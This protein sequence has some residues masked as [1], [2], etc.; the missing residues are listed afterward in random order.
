MVF[1]RLKVYG[2]ALAII[3]IW[4]TLA[5]G[6]KPP[7]L[8][9][10][11]LSLSHSSPQN[12]TEA[13]SSASSIDIQRDSLKQALAGDFALMMRLITDWDVDA[14]L[15]QAKGF[16]DIER[17]PSSDFLR[18]QMLGRAL[19]SP[20]KNELVRL[21]KESNIHDVIDDTN[22]KISL[23]IKYRRFLP[24]TYAA[25]SFLLALVSPSQIVAL[26]SRLREQIELYPKSV[27]DQIFLDIDR[28]N[29]EKLFE[30]DPEIAFVARYSHPSTLQA[31]RNQG[32]QLYMMEDLN[33]LQ[34]ITNELMNIGRLVARPIEAEL[35][36]LFLFSASMALD[37]KLLLLKNQYIKIN[38]PLPTL[39]YVNHHHNF[40]IPTFKTLTG[41]FL[42]KM[43]SW[44]I[45]LKHAEEHGLHEMWTIPI[46]RE[47]IVNLNPDCLI[48]ATEH[49]QAIE[50]QILQD[51]A[52]QQISAV[53]NRNIYFI[54]ESIQQSSCQYILL[55]YYDL[56]DALMRV[57]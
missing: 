8:Q 54:S 9:P 36:K 31:L 19:M 17:L 50:K 42:Q 10:T 25:A 37:N 13:T 44:D 7:S 1:S 52:L 35:M 33:T 21:Q 6:T 34:A 47:H 16:N 27:T 57:K 23:K 5:F 26:P 30:A 45:T 46:D 32:I 14:Q 24:Q 38:K 41:H 2:P 49:P 11:E 29:A 12:A 22:N 15:L 3:I 53:R 48:V 28:F 39:L 4:W 56:I 43:A 20:Y 40:S 18:A 51:S 55:A